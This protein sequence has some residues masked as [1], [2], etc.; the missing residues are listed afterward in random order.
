MR[1]RALEDK[2]VAKKGSCVGEYQDG[3]TTQLNPK[4]VP[5][6]EIRCYAKEKGYRTPAFPSVCKW[7]KERNRPRLIDYQLGQDADYWFIQEGRFYSAGTSCEAE[8]GSSP[9]F[10]LL[11]DRCWYQPPCKSDNSQYCE[12]VTVPYIKPCSALDEL[13]CHIQPGCTWKQ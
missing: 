5:S 4:K 13:S 3:T 9:S 7:Y 6:D 8:Y 1:L 11:L 2:P 12:K 10:T